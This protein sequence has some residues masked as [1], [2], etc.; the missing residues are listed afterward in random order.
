[1]LACLAAVLIASAA[2]DSSAPRPLSQLAHTRWTAKEG[3]PIGIRSLA[4]TADGYLW[5]GTS[6]G[7]VRFDGVRFVPFVPRGGDTLPAVP[8]VQRLLATRD[9]SLW[10]VWRLGAVSRLR[11]GRVTTYGERDGLPTAFQ[12]AESGDGELVAGTLKGLA[13]FAGGRW[14]DVGRAWGFPGTESRAVWFD[15]DGVLWAQTQDRIVY[16]PR[17]ARRFLDPGLLL[18]GGPFRADFDQEEDG[19]VWMSEVNRSAHTLR[20]AGEE[21]VPLTEV[22]SFP[23]ALLV[24]RKGSLWVASVGGGLR[25]VRD[26]GRIRGRAV[27]KGAPEVERLTMADGLLSDDPEALLEDHEGNIWVGSGRGL[28]RFREGDFTPF[29]AWGRDRSRI[30]FA[31]R[32]TL[33]WTSAYGITG[34]ERIDPRGRRDTVATGFSA[35]N[36]AEDASGGIWAVDDRSGILRLEGKRFTPIPLRPGGA[37]TLQYLA[38]DAGGSLW[39]MDSELGLMRLAGDTLVPVARLTE[40]VIGRTSLYG[41]RRG[42]LWVGQLGRVALYDRGKLSVFGAGHGVRPGLV[43]GFFEDRAGEVWAASS[44]GLSR[45]ER[46]RFRTLSERQGIPG[47]SVYGLAQDEAGAWWLATRTGVVR[48]PPGE[49]ERALADSTRSVRSRGFDLN[50]GI[51]GLVPQGYWGPILTRAV[52]GRIW[53]STDSGVAVVDPRRLALRPPP[54]ARIEAVRIDGRELMPSEVLEIPAGRHDLEI[55]YTALSFAAPERVR[56]RYRLEGADGA[57]RDAGTRRRAYYSGLAPGR[58]RFRVAAT[59]GDGAWNETGAAWAFRVLPAWYQTLPFRAGIVLL[60]AASGAAAAALVQR[61]RHLRSQEALKARYEATL[62]ER[63]RIAQDLH[64]S[65]LQGFIGVTLQLKAA[66]SALPGKPDA[67]AETIRRVQLLARESLREARE[68]VW[69]MHR[70]ESDDL[71]AALEAVAR[72]RASGTGIAVSLVVVGERRRLGPALEEAAFRMGR[73]AVANA[74][75]HAGAGRIDIVA[76]YGEDRFVLEVLDDGRGFT[77]EEAEEA[78]RGGHFGL[79]GMRERAMRMGGRCDVRAR[80]GGGTIVEIDLPLAGPGHAPPATGPGT[81][82]APDPPH[83][84]PGAQPSRQAV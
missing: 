18:R 81:A 30:V 80:P 1:M 29:A 45:F 35:V 77:Q 65:L 16:R 42:R 15:R 38:T 31:S 26:P 24:D 33:L 75:R 53:V 46:G 6:S 76:R 11:A 41:D 67:A 55:D 27:R 56:F 44:G 14:Q 22:E 54:P 50:D 74:I 78:R 47:G 60:V 23:A 7:V 43:Y 13:R 3:A 82:A 58:Y 84:A 79:S 72:E 5:L 48:L 28:E 63:G 61:R 25:R 12:L 17:G 49:A 59:T 68:R 52:D 57:W 20:R 40:P 10:V 34:F 71:P 36:L 37:R 51:P 70:S 64:D 32:D 73:E 2:A 4:Q 9:G 69:D 19:T 83:A 62:A 39:A 66:E 21:S 8:S